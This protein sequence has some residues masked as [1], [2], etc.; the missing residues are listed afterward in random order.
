M[1]IKSPLFVLAA[2]SAIALATS[3]LADSDSSKDKSKVEKKNV[4][5]FI[6]KEDDSDAEVKLKINGEAWKFKLPSLS[7]GEERIIATED[8]RTVKAKRSGKEVTVEAGGETVKL[9][10]EGQGMLVR[11]HG[12]PPVPPTPPV[13]G[14]AP[15]APMP[16]MPPQEIEALRNSVVISGVELTDAQQKQIRDAIKKAGV[17]KPVKFIQ[18]NAHMIMHVEHGSPM[19][20]HDGGDGKAVRTVVITKDGETD[21]IESTIEI[22]TTQDASDDKK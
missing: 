19:A 9:P 5:V 16:P 6:N 17:T 4:A 14:V 1:K 20:W 12:V 11:F 13:A 10:A 21:D 15:T 7:D 3:A 18:G 22:E 8:G 2:V